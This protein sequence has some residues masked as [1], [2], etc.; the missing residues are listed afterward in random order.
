MLFTRVIPCLLLKGSGLVKTVKFKD[1]KYVGDPRNALKIF[2][3]K[4]ADEIVILDISATLENRSPNF[5]LI[6]EVVDEAFMPLGYGGGIKNI[7]EIRRLLNIGVEKAIINTAAFQNPHLIEEA[8]KIFGSQSIVIS[9][10]I[11]KSL[12]GSSLVYVSN[13]K[14]STKLDPVIY[15]KKMESLGAGELLINSIDRDGTMTGYDVQIIKQIADAVTIPVVACGGAGKLADLRVAV[16]EGG[17]SAVA[18]GSLFVF[19]GKHR[20]VLISYPDAD[21]LRLLFA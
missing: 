2:N 17:A 15:A 9:I 8:A 16:K 4:E 14:T 3:E 11:K 19:H 12:L 10:D 7:E 21:E 13:G 18:A 20:A 6:R 1:P 5:E